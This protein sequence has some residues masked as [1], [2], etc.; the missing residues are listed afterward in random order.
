[1]ED[2]E[3][4]RE[5]EI[6]R[7]GVDNGRISGARSTLDSG[8]VASSLES[9]GRGGKESKGGKCACEWRFLD[10]AGVRDRK[11]ESFQPLEITS[12]AIHGIVPGSLG[13]R[14]SSCCKCSALCT[15]VL[16]RMEYAAG[17]KA[18]ARETAVVEAEEK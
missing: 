12:G 17:G 7:R 11:L 8:P 14:G 15:P 16:S 1:M 10:L 18:T 3:Y 9:S 6:D 2:G 13:D 5:L 4:G